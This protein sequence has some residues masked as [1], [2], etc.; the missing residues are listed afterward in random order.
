MTRR[1][2]RLLDLVSFIIQTTD[3]NLHYLFDV[4]CN[5]S[6]TI[7]SKFISYLLFCLKLKVLDPSLLQSHLQCPFG[8]CGDDEVLLYFQVSRMLMGGVKVIGIYIWVT[9]S[10]FKNSTISLCQVYCHFLFD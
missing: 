3:C 5:S 4:A 6:F 2:N 8:M 1:L 9:D 7:I 10:L